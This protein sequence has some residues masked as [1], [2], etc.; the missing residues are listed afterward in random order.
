MSTI[1]YNILEGIS[2]II[3]VILLF[4][5]VAVLAKYYFKVAVTMNIFIYLFSISYYF[6]HTNLEMFWCAFVF[7]LAVYY[8]KKGV[9]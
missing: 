3:L 8:A 1:I 2:V 9:L 5:G 6:K 4:V 7:S